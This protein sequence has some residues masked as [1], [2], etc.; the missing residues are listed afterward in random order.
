MP[1][2]SFLTCPGHPELTSFLV[3]KLSSLQILSS[4]ESVAILRKVKIKQNAKK[5][6]SH[7]NSLTRGLAQTN[8]EN[9]TNK[10]SILSQNY[11]FTIFNHRT[12]QQRSS[13]V[14]CTVNKCINLVLQN[15]FGWFTEVCPLNF[16]PERR[17][18]IKSMQNIGHKQ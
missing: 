5:H 1:L 9:F 18:Q 3:T 11:H 2:I 10:D 7:R 17:R 13:N 8:I 4:I 16:V 12:K 14:G 15:G 6:R